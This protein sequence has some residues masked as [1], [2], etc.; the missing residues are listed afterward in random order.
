M[1]R[2]GRFI[3]ILFIGSKKND[4]KSKKKKK[5]SAL[6]FDGSHL[7]KDPVVEGPFTYTALDVSENLSSLVSNAKV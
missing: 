3:S 1:C 2:D 6:I 5:G 7:A 4:P